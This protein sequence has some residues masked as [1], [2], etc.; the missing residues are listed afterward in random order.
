MLSTSTYSRNTSSSVWPTRNRG[1]EKSDRFS[2]PS[3]STEKP[4]TPSCFTFT[5]SKVS[6][7]ATASAKEG[8]AEIADT[9]RRKQTRHLPI[10]EMI[11]DIVH[12]HNS[13]LGRL[14]NK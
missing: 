10:L 12:A 11:P 2:V 4:T 14:L 13:I 5:L 3:D 8:F 9:S 6:C 7:G 1:P